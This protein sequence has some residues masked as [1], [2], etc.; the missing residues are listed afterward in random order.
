MN[1]EVIKNWI[2]KADEDLKV[3]RHELNQPAEERATGAICFHAQQAAEKYMKAYLLTKS[4]DLPKSHDLEY[5]LAVCADNDK[6]FEKLDIGNLTDYAVSVRYPDD[7][8]TPSFEEAIKA[9]ELAN[10]IKQFVSKKIKT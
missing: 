10:N 3:V 5:L 8:Y 9:S 7:F 6:D 1:E 2:K 4:I